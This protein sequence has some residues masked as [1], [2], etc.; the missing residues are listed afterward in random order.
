MDK[1]APGKIN[2]YD[3]FVD[4]DCPEFER[5]MRGETFMSGF[6]P[7]TSLIVPL[8]FS[9]DLSDC[10]VMHVADV[11]RRYTA[12]DA[13]H[14]D[15]GISQSSFELKDN[16]DVQQ[17]L[18]LFLS[19][20]CF[21]LDSK[22]MERLVC[23]GVPMNT[24]KQAFIHEL[25]HVYDNQLA[26]APAARA[27]KNLP[28]NAGPVSQLDGMY[29]VID[30]HS[31]FDMNK[32]TLCQRSFTDFVYMTNVTEVKA[33]LS[34][35]YRYVY[36]W[37]DKFY[38][39]EHLISGKI[40]LVVYKTMRDKGRM[41]TEA[42]RRN[43][44]YMIWLKFPRKYKLDDLPRLLTTGDAGWIDDS[45]IIYT[46]KNAVYVSDPGGKKKMAAGRTFPIDYIFGDNGFADNDFTKKFIKSLKTRYKLALVAAKKA[47]AIAS[48]AYDDFMNEI[49]YN[50]IKNDPSTPPKTGDRRSAANEN[51]GYPSV[52]NIGNGAVGTLNMMG[53]Q[54][55]LLPVTDDLQQR[56]N[57]PSNFSYIH[58][59]T[60]VRAAGFNDPDIKYDGVVTKIVRDASGVVTAVYILDS[61]TAK[62]KK[63]SPDR[64]TP[65]TYKQEYGIGNEK[66]IIKD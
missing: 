59:G 44:P 62:T 6:F 13:S 16:V 8:K 1:S 9:A 41:I 63:V 17:Q 56:K 37:L 31:G 55:N 12:T 40:H 46:Y 23:P 20:W 61:S 21:D 29:C 10:D 14:A 5:A 18:T 49:F 2:A 36:D 50:E 33:Y 39:D 30:T 24:S 53:Y 66:E 27:K 22:S 64:I 45:E 7:D 51:Y 25:M 35:L 28:R 60:K 58:V 11:A 42:L 43:R 15:G 48:E 54:Y 38:G 3:P 65:V 32:R 57:D 34:S 4:I 47:A 52:M 26:N 19:D